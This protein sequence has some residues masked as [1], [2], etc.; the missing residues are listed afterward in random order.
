MYGEMHFKHQDTFTT[1]SKPE[2]MGKERA[3][4]RGLLDR[5]GDT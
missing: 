5:S 4:Q 3:L 2:E 1:H